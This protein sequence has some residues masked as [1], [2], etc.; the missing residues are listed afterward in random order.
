[1]FTMLCTI[2]EME[3]VKVQRKSTGLQIRVPKNIESVLDDVK[4][5]TCT[6]DKDGIHY[7]P[8]I[9]K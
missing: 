1:M 7:K 5:V 8:I 9:A 3:I 2:M 4:Y 6:T